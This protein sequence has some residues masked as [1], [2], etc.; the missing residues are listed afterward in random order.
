MLDELN[1]SAGAYAREAAS[2]LLQ[3]TGVAFAGIATFFLQTFIFLMTL[4]YLLRDGDRLKQFLI[5]VSPLRDTDDTIIFDKLGAAVNSVVKGK[6]FIGLIQG[7]LTGI[8]FAFFGVPS[9][10]LWG[11]IA[12]VFSLVPPLGTALVTVPAIFYLFFIGDMFSVIGLT[13]WGI[14]GVGLVDNILGPKMIG[15]GMQLHPLLVLLA[16]LGGLAF[17]GPIGLFLGPLTV[18]LLVALLSLYRHFSKG[19][20]V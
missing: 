15:R 14:F 2:W 16:V 13:I 9:P 19:E 3:H 4:Y 8:G 17:F 18:S 7:V 12:A 11:F 1:L 5:E 20:A 6:L 10:V